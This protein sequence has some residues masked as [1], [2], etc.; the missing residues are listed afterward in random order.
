MNADGG[1]R[2][3][4]S[5][6]HDNA[7]MTLNAV[8]MDAMRAPNTK[9]RCRRRCRCHWTYGY[10]P[11]NECD[12]EGDCDSNIIVDLHKW[13]HCMAGARECRSSPVSSHSDCGCTMIGACNWHFDCMDDGWMC[14]KRCYTLSMVQYSH[15][16]FLFSDKWVK[17]RKQEKIIKFQRD[18]D[19]DHEISSDEYR[20]PHDFTRKLPCSCFCLR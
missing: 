14:Y 1:T 7:L 2:Q 11:C 9:D 3:P 19:Y 12:C 10:S 16:N 18:D 4:L 13:P 6:P 8:S 20:M 17:R 5:A 15:S